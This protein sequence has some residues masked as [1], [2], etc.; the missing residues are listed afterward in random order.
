MG[1]LSTSGKQSGGRATRRRAI[2]VDLVAESLGEISAAKMAALLASEATLEEFEEALAWANGESD[3]LGKL[4]MR[5]DGAA[6]AVYDILTAE[7]EDAD[8]ER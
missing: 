6:A 7:R 1:S 8:D 5:L 4:E 2:T 3:V